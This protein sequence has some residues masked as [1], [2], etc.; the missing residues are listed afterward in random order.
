VSACALKQFQKRHAFWSTLVQRIT[1][2]YQGGVNKTIL[3]LV[4]RDSDLL[5]S[6]FWTTNPGQG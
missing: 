6:T 3:L 5:L 2:V 1:Q 4:L